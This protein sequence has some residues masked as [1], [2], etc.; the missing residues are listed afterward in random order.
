MEYITT[1]TPI[2]VTTNVDKEISLRFLYYKVQELVDIVIRVIKTYSKDL[3]DIK[4]EYR[5]W[6]HHDTLEDKIYIDNIKPLLPTRLVKYVISKTINNPI[7]SNLVDVNIF[8]N[9]NT[10]Q[11]VIPS[12]TKGAVTDI[13]KQHGYEITK[14]LLSVGSDSCVYFTPMYRLI[15]VYK[16]LDTIEIKL[17]GR[18]TR[19]FYIKAYQDIEEGYIVATT[20]PF[21]GTPTQK[22]V[23]KHIPNYTKYHRYGVKLALG[24]LPLLTKDTPLPLL[25]SIRVLH[26][27]V[28]LKNI[29][30]SLYF[31][32]PISE[33]Y[34]LT[35][36]TYK[37]SYSITYNPIDKEYTLVCTKVKQ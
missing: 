16:N 13:P 4:P 9:E 22:E 20:T 15:T 34:L 19:P 32:R 29:Y 26:N 27:N 6:I 10:G 8:Y 12:F 28:Y 14:V 33:S 11:Y 3:Y 1:G 25:D 21:I 7:K 30:Q 18:S 36:L 35:L 37:Y 24:N 2:K 17:I 5:K 31:K 23:L